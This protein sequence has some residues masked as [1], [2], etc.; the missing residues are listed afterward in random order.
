MMSRSVPGLPGKSSEKE[1]KFCRVGG[2][3]VVLG[4]T[5]LISDDF[6]LRNEG[7]R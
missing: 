1:E 6:D 2:I 7:E 3:S 5:D 4:L